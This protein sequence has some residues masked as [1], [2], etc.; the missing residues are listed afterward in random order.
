MVEYTYNCGSATGY[1]WL[2]KAYQ[3]NNTIIP[4]TLKDSISDLIGQHINQSVINGKY[5][6]IPSMG[7]YIELLDLITGINDITYPLGLKVNVFPSPTDNIVN[8]DTFLQK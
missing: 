8:Q 5:L 3:L 2:M 7:E 1:R 6:D 4:N